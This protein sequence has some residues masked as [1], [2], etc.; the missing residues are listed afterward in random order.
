VHVTYIGACP[1]AADPVIDQRLMPDEFLHALND[2]DIAL[3]DMPTVFDSVLPPDRRRCFSLPGGCPS[4]EA[5]WQASEGRMLREVTQ[6]TF[7]T[8]LAQTLLWREYVMIDVAPSLGCACAGSYSRVGTRY[9]RVAVMALEPPRA[10]Q[11]VVTYQPEFAEVEFEE[12]GVGSAAGGVAP[13]EETTHAAD[14][15]TSEE[16]LQRRESEAPTSPVRV[17][18]ANAPLPRA[19][20]AKRRHLTAPPREVQPEA[21]VPLPQPEAVT[22]PT[23]NVESAQAPPPVAVSPEEQVITWRREE[24]V[25]REELTT[26]APSA[27]AYSH[28]DDWFAQVEVHYSEQPS[29]REVE[30]V[31][32]VSTPSQ[33]PSFPSSGGESEKTSHAPP[34][35]HPDLGRPI[36]VHVEPAPAVV[37]DVPVVVAPEPPEEPRRDEREIAMERESVVAVALEE[38]PPPPPP[39]LKTPQEDHAPPSPWERSAY[40]DHEVPRGAAPSGPLRVEVVIDG[41]LEAPPPEVIIPDT[42]HDDEM[43][44]ASHPTVEI[45]THPA[46]SWGD[47]LIALW[48]VLVAS[49]VLATLLWRR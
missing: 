41:D 21:T 40:A 49:A 28:T 1:G 19:Y 24:T 29:E 11:P 42:V 16:E 31:R 47:V 45:V 26:R 3:S 46:R 27:N 12:P 30:L 36:S 17:R 35:E 14:L 39:S 18:A 15:A 44:A 34:N 20:L 37:E 43:S 33:A 13:V 2:R 32:D 38:P 4:Q 5:L 6:P 7:S 25:L 48:L 8:D 22:E 9:G 23:P 10:A